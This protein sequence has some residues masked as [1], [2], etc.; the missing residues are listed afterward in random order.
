VSSEIS[1]DY[2]NSKLQAV[3]QDPNINAPS[4]TEPTGIDY[5]GGDFDS[6]N[7]QEDAAPATMERLSK[8]AQKARD[9]EA[10]ILKDAVALEELK[11]EHD[12]ITKRFIPGIMEELGMAKFTL[13]DGAEVKIKESVNASISAE[14]KPEAFAWLTKNDFDGIIKTKVQAEFGRGEIE[15]ARKALAA[16]QS[17]GFDAAID[18]SVHPMTLKS[19]VKERLEAG[20][21]IPI[22]VFGIFESKEAK[23]TLPKSRK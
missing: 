22:D 21:S 3:S 2:L 23:I 11:G 12:K 17:A 13:T 15:S 1:S 20:D 5:F 6:E 4:S 7:L 19:F 8:L 10:K 14:N 16:I 9:L 18:Q